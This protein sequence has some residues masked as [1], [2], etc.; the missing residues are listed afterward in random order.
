MKPGPRAH[1]VSLHRTR[2]FI[3]PAQCSH[4]TAA[5]GVTLQLYIIYKNGGSGG[6]TTQTNLHSKI[7]ELV[8]STPARG[9]PWTRVLDPVVFKV[10]FFFKASVDSTPAEITG[11]VFLDSVVFKE[12]EFS[13][14]GRASVVLSARGFL[15]SCFLDP[16]IFKD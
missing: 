15:D 12:T 4:Q 1:L 5:I 3:F 9:V 6:S 10:E 13:F 11:L 16:V 7:I 14:I 8:D 2:H